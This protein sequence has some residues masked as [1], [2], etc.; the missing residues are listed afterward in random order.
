MAARNP[1][2]G[3]PTAPDQAKFSDRLRRVV[4]TTRLETTGGS[5]KQR[6][7]RLIQLQ[8]PQR[9]PPAERTHRDPAAAA[10]PGR[11]IARF[12]HAATSAPERFRAA[13]RAITTISDRPGHCARAVRNHSRMRLFKRLRTTALPIRLL[14]VTPNRCRAS[15]EIGASAAASDLVTTTKLRETRRCPDLTTRLKSRVRKMRSARPK[16]PVFEDTDLLR[17]NVGGEALAALRPAALENCASSACLHARAKSMCSFPADTARLISAFHRRPFILV[18]S[19]GGRGSGTSFPSDI[20]PCR[21]ASGF[22]PSR[23]STSSG[24]VRKIVSPN[25][26]GRKVSDRL[27]FA[28]TSPSSQRNPPTRSPGAC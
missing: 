2:H 9:D 1:T 12:K 25:T 27:S 16:R 14:T 13:G 10:R 24:L 28:P 19:V 22:S 6:K 8:Q 21:H 23:A 17:G 15:T 20:R 5:K 7:R 11:S 4:R 18:V 3:Q 26:Q